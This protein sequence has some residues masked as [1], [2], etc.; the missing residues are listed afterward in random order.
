MSGVCRSACRLP[1]EVKDKSIVIGVVGPCSAGKSTL[2]S[3]LKARDYRN[4]RHIAQEHS[5]V[6]DMWQRL[7]DPDILVYLDVSYAESMRRRPLRMSESEFEEQIYRLRHAR[8][9]ADLY[10]P[11]D[12]LSIEQVLTTVIAEINQIGQPK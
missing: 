10:L 11:T 5:F 6:E 4:I 8:R 12:Q 3:G 7:V 9:H 2:V 1:T